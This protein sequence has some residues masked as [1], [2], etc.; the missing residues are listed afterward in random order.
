M[1]HLH[2][3]GE[4]RFKNGVRQDICVVL[5]AAVAFA[6]ENVHGA[7]L[8]SVLPIAH[9]QAPLAKFQFVG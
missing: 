5:V 1:R 7:E 9:F 8:N 3:L 2:Q 4:H 6:D